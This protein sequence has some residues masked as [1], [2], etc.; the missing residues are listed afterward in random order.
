VAGTSD[1]AQ[2]LIDR[3]R[4]LVRLGVGKDPERV[5][6]VIRKDHRVQRT[7]GNMCKSVAQYQDHLS[8]S[9]FQDADCLRQDCWLA[10]FV[11]RK[12]GPTVER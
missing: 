3:E 7:E 12:S 6:K 9:G 11:A 8:V 1:G 4:A 5:P 10:V 2:Y